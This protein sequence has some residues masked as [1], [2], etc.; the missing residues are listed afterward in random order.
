LRICL[1]LLLTAG[2]VL[3]SS[4]G[5]GGRSNLVQD[6]SLAGNWQFSMAPPSDGSFLGGL[7][8]GFLLQNGGAVTGATNYAVSLTN[9]LVPCNSGTAQVTGTLSGQAVTLSAVAGTQTFAL[10]G[11]LSLDG[12]SMAG[13]YDSTQGTAPD[14]T[15]CGTAQTNLQWSASLVPPLTGS[16]QGDFQ[17]SD[18]AAGLA[19]Q[20]FLVTGALNQATN[21]GASTAAVSGNLTFL[22]QANNK[23]DYPCFAT[24]SV[25]GQISGNTTT[26]QLA[27][28]DGT[29]WGFIGEPVG[30][31]GGTGVNPVTL[32][33]VNGGYVLRGAGPS[34]LV[35]TAACPGSL[36]STSTA[37]DFGNVCLALNGSSACQQ[38]I[39]LVPAALTFS[40]QTLQAP[41]TTQPITLTNATNDTLGG[42]SLSLT[43]NSGALNFTET[44][45]CGVNGAPSMGQPFAL[46]GTLSCV[47]SITFQPLELCAPGT[48]PGNCPAPLTATLTV[49][50]SSNE[51]IFTVPIVGTATS[52]TAI[53]AGEV[54]Q[55]I[56]FEPQQSARN[57]SLQDVE[58][59]A[60]I[61]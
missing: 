8:G 5:G 31:L 58:Q 11:T 23:S 52:G 6:L 30:S 19:E 28:G 13:T 43:N 22:N 42:L 36:E 1:L 51:T 56:D 47:V 48:P 21:T 12:L 7:Q 27:G 60:T 57:W 49:T 32:D 53:S 14:G 33:T 16:I 24:A 46:L 4:C 34:Y 20:V 38:P 39:S 35:A 15:I 17:S 44:D 26:L 37:G 29:E 54:K 10:T 40:S 61:N 18:S 41:A 25:T 50:S 2:A 3:L 9:L 45:N 55:V 59:H